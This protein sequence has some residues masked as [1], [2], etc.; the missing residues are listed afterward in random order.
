LI[1]G[2]VM[3]EAKNVES[4]G[5]VV[6]TKE[7]LP[8]FRKWATSATRFGNHCWTQIS[9]S[10]RQTS[11]FNNLHPVAPSKVK[12]KRLGFFASPRPLTGTEINGL[13]S[14]YANAA[15]LSKEAGFTG[16]Q[17]HAAHGYLISQFLSPITNKRDDQW[18][19]PIENRSRFLFEV[20]KRSRDAV[21]SSFPISVK[22]NSSDFQKGGFSEAESQWVIGR[23]E[24]LGIDLLEIS[25]GTYENAVFLVDEGLRQ[26]TI[27]REAYFI[28]FARK[29]KD[30]SSVP[31]MVTGGI[32][33][34][35]F[36]NKALSEGTLDMVGIARPF[37]LYN[38]FAKRF[39]A[40]EVE[41]EVK[42]IRTGIKSFEDLAE[43]GYYNLILERLGKGKKIKTSY[44]PTRSAIHLIKHEFIKA[45]AN[46]LQ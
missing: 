46:K 7:A 43:A 40:G 25:G 38:N 24:E 23:L 12:L 44:S 39:L 10:G 11:I 13:I 6:I 22:I 15:A 3:I 32:R 36:S 28:E 42:R 30:A 27:K 9:H 17:I 29:V 26:S 33:S 35:N 37:L 18:G 41:A 20:I 2:N 1:T 14:K 5:N 34:L 8:E 31:V 4:A 21:G 16:I 19:G 45:M